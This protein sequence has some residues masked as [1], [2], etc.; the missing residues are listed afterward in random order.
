MGSSNQASD[1]WESLCLAIRPESWA[2]CLEDCRRAVRVF[3]GMVM[4]FQAS[5]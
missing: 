4:D 3:P 1:H 2:W 5:D